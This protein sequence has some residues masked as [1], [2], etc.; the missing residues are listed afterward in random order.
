MKNSTLGSAAFLAGLMI[1][2]AAMAAPKYTLTL[3]DPLP[4]YE[5]SIARAISDNG[6][7]VGE[8]MYS[9]PVLGGVQRAFMWNAGTLTDIGVLS[10]SDSGYSHSMALGVNN[11]GQ[12]VGNSRAETGS[13]HAFVWDSISGMTD[14]TPDS[15]FSIA[16]G[17][18]NNGQ[19]A[20]LG[21]SSPQVGFKWQSGSISDLGDLP[22]GS[23]LS[24][25][26]AIND[27]GQIAGQSDGEFGLH[28]FL[29]EDGG[30]VT[31]LGDL[32][33][34]DNY[35]L[36]T[37]INEN[38][39][40]VGTSGAETGFHAFIWQSGVM[41]DLGDLPG[42]PLGGSDFSAAFGINDSG[43]VVGY[44]SLGAFLWDED[45]GMMNLN[46][47]VVDLTGWHLNYAFAIN[48]SG[49]IVGSGSYNGGGRAFLL[50]P[51]VESVPEPVTFGLLSAGLFG[52]GAL[53]RR[54]RAVG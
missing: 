48:D 32:P 5:S 8:S 4:G 54:R 9:D 19:A 49:L 18:N 11:S 45:F 36:A 17:I 31:D 26:F 1:S 29:Q 43:Q 44:G 16:Y 37:G 38:G 47:L 42:G 2:G 23:E 10:T 20:G 35:S 13:L 50:T 24:R 14:I 33:G 52:V 3:I 41:I 27:N 51:M 21:G 40:V 53:R 7:V 25:G 28:A 39:Q 22:G 34:G 12:V 46:D 6:Y 30:V 15:A